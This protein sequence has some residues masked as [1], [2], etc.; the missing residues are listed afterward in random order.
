MRTTIRE[1]VETI[2]LAVFLVLIL[3][4]TV[5]NYRVDGPSMNPLLASQDRVLVNKVIYTEVDANRVMRFIPG[6]S[7]EVGET[8]H[9]FNPPQRGDTIV[10]RWPRDITQNFVKRVIG[11]PGDRVQIRGGA[12]FINDVAIDE[13]YVTRPKNETLAERTIAEGEYYVLGDNRAQS[14]DSR[15]W[16]QVDEGLVVGKVSLAYWPLDRFSVLTP[17]WLR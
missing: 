11:L 8:W 3:Q 1:A 7:A 13:P 6:R 14:D 12:V 5:Q 16:G 4:N 15:H 9:P 2:T 10:F 17:R